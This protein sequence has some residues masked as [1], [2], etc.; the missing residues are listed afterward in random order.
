VSIHQRRRR[1]F[2]AIVLFGIVTPLILPILGPQWISPRHVFSPDHSDTTES[3]IFWQLRL[4]RVIS[5]YLAGAALAIAGMVFQAIFRNPLATPFTL[6][7]SSGAA[8]GAA[9]AVKLGVVFVVLGISGVAVFS[10]GGAILTICIVYFLTSLRRDFS[11]ETM[12][13]AGVALSFLFSAAILVVQYLSDFTGSFQLVRWLMGNLNTVGYD[14][15][16]RLLVILLPCT[17]AVFF[18]RRDLNLLLSGD[19]MATTRGVNVKQVRLVIFFVVSLLTGT[20]VAF[21]GPIGFV[22][23]MIPHILRMLLGTEHGRLLWGC[24]FGGGAFL[25]LCDT[26]ARTVIAPAEVPVGI[27]TALLGGPF[28]LWLL[29][30]RKGNRFFF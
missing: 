4:P 13:L 12:L 18:Y 26:V 22:G 14:Q 20:V 1:I 8:F 25:A 28:F 21:C 5:G 7:V 16:I 9:M 3:Q 27:L 2:S 30:R 19:E 24:I 23:M 11:T 10:F 15:P 6:G 17:L 29:I